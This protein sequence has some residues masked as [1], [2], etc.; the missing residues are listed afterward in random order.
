[1]IEIEDVLHL[2]AI[3]IGTV[4][5]NFL[6]NTCRGFKAIE[7]LKENLVL[8]NN[9]EALKKDERL[10]YMAENWLARAYGEVAGMCRHQG[11]YVTAK[12]LLKKALAIDIQIG[13]KKGEAADNGNLGT[14]FQCVDQYL[15]A[16]EYHEKALATAIEIGDRNGEASSYVSLGSVFLF[17]SKHVKAEKYFEKAIAIQIEISDR[18]GEASSYGGLGNVLFSLGE[19]VKAK[20]YYEK[21]LAISK[22]TNDR[23]GEGTCYGN[24]GDVFQGLGQYFQAKAYY[25]KALAIAMESGDKSGERSMC[26]NLGN[27]FCSLGEYNKAVTYHEKALAISKI[28][29]ERRGEATGYGSLATV[30]LSLGEYVKGEKY[31][32]KA[33]TIREEIGDK[34][35]QAS[36]FVNLGVMFESV[37]EYDKAE[38]Y[39]EEALLIQTEIGDRHGQAWSYEKL[40]NV[41]ASLGIFVKAKTYH[42]EALGIRM[43]IG[44]RA[45]TAWSFGNLGNVLQ[46]LGE[47]V[48]AKEYY[49]KAV[50][51]RLEIGDRRGEAADY[52]NLGEVSLTLGQYAKAEEYQRKS[53]AICKEIGNKEGEASSYGNLGHIFHSLGEYVKAK[54]HCEKALTIVIEIGDKAREATIYGNLGTVFHALGKK[55]KAEE[56]FEKAL[57]ISQEIGDKKGKAKLYEYLGGMF[58]FNGGNHTKAREYFDK[59]LAICKEI[60]YREGEAGNYRGLGKVSQ[61]LGE[62]VMAEKYLEK[63]LSIAKDIGDTGEVF[64]CYCILIVVKLSQGKFHEAFSHLLQGIEKCEDLRYSLAGNDQF[65]ILFS[66]KH[67]FPYQLLSELFCDTGNQNEALY[68][69]ELGRARGLA[70]LMTTKYSVKMQISANPESWVGMENIMRKESNCT[71]LYIAYKHQDIFLWILKTGGVIHFRRIE[72]NGHIVKHRLVKDLDDFFPKSFRRFGILS[73]EECEDRSLKGIQP[74]LKSSQ[75]EGPASLRLVEDDDDDD[76]ES[77]EPEPSLSLYYKM[78]IAPVADLLEDREIIIVPDRFLYRVPFAALHDGSGKYLS[79]TFWIRIVPSLMTL[80]LIQDSPADYHS[81]TGALIVGDPKGEGLPRLPCARKEAKMIG[82]LLGVQPLLA[83]HATKQAVLQRINSASLI[84]FAAHGNA[85]R[86][87]IALAPQCTSSGVPEEEDYLLTMSDISQVHLRAKLV[88]LSC[89]HSGS[90]Q[91]RTEG[92]VGIARAFLGSGARSVLVAMWAIE[93]TATEQFMRLFYEHL[94]RG[95][96]ASECLHEAMKWMRSNGYSEVAQWAPFMLIGD[97]V[98]LEF[99]K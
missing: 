65:K 9:N 88:V 49:E 15:K 48:K 37:G 12:E 44:D 91:I 92:V 41:F 96:S 95:E 83:E 7:L 31:L 17:H 73:E 69:V 19:Y 59:S 23:L 2:E 98:T 94:V 60:G 28:T 82:R 36:C 42:E 86:G 30:C 25:K 43:R 55:G 52:G 80:K 58:V 46:S 53:L 24:I 16:E 45:G 90:G 11:K 3:V 78:L 66:N 75:K 40:G 50:A 79:E 6:L 38:K 81:Q 33:L 51:I 57:A 62:Y 21:S 29:G 18:R 63:A 68:V 54:E 32:E 77:Q 27:V 47:N 93:D 87:E 34:R 1:M 13:N 39:L 67:V 56:F 5:A 97:N 26:S 10:H 4:V 64:K 84:H 22:E 20:E 70:D 76:E 61:D 74:N 14:V 35:G 99:G 72:V 85:E 89:C 71:C 8:L